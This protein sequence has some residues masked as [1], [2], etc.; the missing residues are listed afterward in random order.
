M[1]EKKTDKR[2]DFGRHCEFMARTYLEQQG[3]LILETN[4]RSGHKEIDII[5]KEKDT[6]VI[7]EVKARKNEDFINTESAVDEKKMRNLIRAAHNYI[8]IKNLD[9]ETRFD[10]ITLVLDEK[11]EYK[12][13]H[14]KDAFLPILNV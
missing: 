10:I 9:C 2:H 5:A 13:N 6:L 12:L 8:L 14:I 4:W 3:Y 1:E 11:G 7:V